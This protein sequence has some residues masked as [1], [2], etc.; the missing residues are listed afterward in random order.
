MLRKQIVKNRKFA[1]KCA[2]QFICLVYI[3][4]NCNKMFT[5]R[6]VEW[7]GDESMYKREIVVLGFCLLNFLITF[8][9]FDLCKLLCVLLVYLYFSFIVCMKVT[10]EKLNILANLYSQVGNILKI[11]FENCL[12]VSFLIWC[13]VDVTDTCNILQR[14][15]FN[16]KA[17]ENIKWC[18]TLL[19]P[20]PINGF[21]LP[22]NGFWT[23]V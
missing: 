2:D 23:L 6:S 17:L 15:F 21:S 5:F 8:V 16:K 13:L 20:L 11:A 22:I 19:S 4:Y 7:T 18:L 3:V 14:I 12:H 9:Q 1:S 10:A